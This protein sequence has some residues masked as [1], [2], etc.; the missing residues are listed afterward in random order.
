MQRYVTYMDGSDW[1][2]SPLPLA[3]AVKP[4]GQDV[5]QVAGLLTAAH[6]EVAV[7]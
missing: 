1:S 6:L 5:D 7:V 4:D 2:Q 3:T